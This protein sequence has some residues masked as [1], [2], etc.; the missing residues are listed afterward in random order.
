MPTTPM[1]AQPYMP[2]LSVVDRVMTGWRMLGNTAGFNMTGHPSLSVPCGM[3]GGL[4][5]SLMLT[6]RHFEDAL[7]LRTARAVERQFT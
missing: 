2:N 4:P 3:S 5:L 7:L 1:K 6:G